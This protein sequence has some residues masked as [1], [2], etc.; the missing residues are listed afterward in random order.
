MHPVWSQSLALGVDSIDDQHKEI[1][2]HVADLNEAL[3]AG[4]S[5]GIALM[6]A[7][8]LERYVAEHFADEERLMKEH[9]YPALQAHLAEHEKFRVAFAEL[10]ARHAVAPNVEMMQ[11]LSKLTTDWLVHH[12]AGTDKAFA[13]YLKDKFGG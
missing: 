12:I 10:R 5:A 4:R 2:L 13:M 3:D 9:Q 7:D 6:L 1:F 8:F 11:T